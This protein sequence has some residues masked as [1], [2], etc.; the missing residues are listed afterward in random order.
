MV[1]F[2]GYQ[3]KRLNLVPMTSFTPWWTLEHIELPAKPLDYFL[4]RRST[5][6][7]PPGFSTANLSTGTTFVSA[8]AEADPSLA[9][10]VSTDAALAQ[11]VQLPLPQV[12]TLQP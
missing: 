10:A 4:W 7:L 6:A 12:P 11:R 2:V 9:G 3:A 1:W 5:A 8:G